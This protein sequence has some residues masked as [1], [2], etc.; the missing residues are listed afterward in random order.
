MHAFM[1]VE[2]ARERGKYRWRERVREEWSERDRQQ[3][4]TNRDERGRKIRFFV[5]MCVREISLSLSLRTTGENFTWEKLHKFFEGKS[6]Q[7]RML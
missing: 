4:K 1:C 3:H 7:D 5:Y 6:N 2:R